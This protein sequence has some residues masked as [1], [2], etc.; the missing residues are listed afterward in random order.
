MAVVFISLSPIMHRMELLRHYRKSRKL[1]QK[2][3][4]EKLGI[5][6]SDLSDYE[7]GNK[8]PRPE[9]AK[10]IAAITGLPRDYL[11]FGD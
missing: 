4:A 8:K 7:R 2:Q 6:Q 11:I 5:N 3:L 10:R 9:T 1:S